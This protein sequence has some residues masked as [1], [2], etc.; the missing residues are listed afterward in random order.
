MTPRPDRPAAVPA[1]ALAA[2]IAL[3]AAPAPAAEG[4]WKGTISCTSGWGGT[5]RLAAEMTA[6]GDQMQVK[7]G[8][9]STRRPLDRNGS[10]TVGITSGQD[11]RV[12]HVR[13]TI[14]PQGLVMRQDGGEV[15]CSGLLEATAPAAPS[16]T[17]PA[18]A[19]AAAPAPSR[20]APSPA[21]VALAAPTLPLTSSRIDDIVAILQRER[22]LAAQRVDETRKLAESPD[23]AGGSAEERADF[24]SR[25]AFAKWS[26]ERNE[27]AQA[28]FR[29]AFDI[30]RQGNALP[31]L[32]RTWYQYHLGIALF[33]TGDVAQ[34]LG[35]LRQSAGDLQVPIRQRGDNE[36]RLLWH[37]VV[38]EGFLARTQ[39]ATGDLAAAEQALARAEAGFKRLAEEPGRA[40]PHE[41]AI[42]QAA[43]AQAR[44]VRAEL[45]GNAAEADEHHRAAIEALATYVSWPQ[46]RWL[47]ANRVE[48]LRYEALLAR[49]DSL[50]RAGRPAEA[51][52]I[53]RQVIDELGKGGGGQI[54][55]IV[56]A[57]RVIIEALLAQGRPADA[58]TLGWLA[59]NALSSAGGARDSALRIELQLALARAD[60]AE[61]VWPD[62]LTVFENLRTDLKGDTQRLN[63][64]LRGDPT[65]AVA[66]LKAG[67]NAE[68]LAAATAARGIAATL[69]G[70]RHPATA[71]AIG[72]R[73]AALSALGRR[74]EAMADFRLAMP[75]L[76]DAATGPYAGES[77]ARSQRLRFTVEAYL[78]ELARGIAAGP[79]GV[80][81]TGAQTLA[82]VD[83]MFRAAEA[84]RSRTLLDAIATAAVRSGLKDRALADLIRRDQ[85]AA[86]RVVALYDSLAG[87]YAL[88]GNMRRN[89]DE[90]AVRRLI[91]EAEAER[92]R[93]NR[94]IAQ[95]APSAAGLVRPLPVALNDLRLALRPG[96]ALV[97]V[98]A[99]DQR[100][101]VIAVPQQ[102]APAVLEAPVGR[103]ALAESVAK[104]RAAMNDT[105]R[106]IEALAPFDVQVAYGEIYRPLLQ[107]LEP[108]FAGA[109]RLLVVADGALAQ[110]PW[111]LLPTSA[112][113]AASGEAGVRFGEYRRVAWLIRRQS[114]AHLPSATAL[115]ALR[116]MAPTAAAPRPFIG[117]GD[118]I[119]SEGPAAPGGARRGSM[120]LRSVERSVA[121]RALEGL[122]PLPDT[123]IEL[124]QIAKVLG[125][126]PQTELYLGARASEGQ[127][128]GAAL[129]RY[130]VVAF[131]THGLA[132]GEI[133][134]LTQPALALSSPKVT[135]EQG[136]GFLTMAEVLD[137]KL[138][139]DWVVLSACNTAGAVQPGDEVLS[140]LASAFFYAGARSVLVT[141]WGVE[142]VSA[143]LLTTGAFSV[144]SPDRAEALRQSILALIDGKSGDGTAGKTK[145]AYAHPLFWAPFAL[146]GDPG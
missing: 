127:V 105:G 89:E 146:V 88:P 106:G 11:D 67:R 140:G 86:R 85:D 115:V 37:A 107:P 49:A 112:A 142:T 26:L 68:A 16:A 70:E 33:R 5:E 84:A 117:V 130:R 65:Y 13:G 100:S 131:A 39:I 126:N 25:R 133:D 40:Q 125:A 87:W 122:P 59:V 34:A 116:R 94:E 51:Q 109:K 53:A 7:L 74:D 101:Y 2:L 81:A 27:E 78:G 138:A 118:P 32:D 108:S 12:G 102:G 17:P 110:I 48:Q 134:G 113:S 79:G 45:R 92:D 20:L 10:F 56:S 90:A 23:P 124:E 58:A 31:V 22:D 132:A 91:A 64:A 4:S 129:D 38:W 18:A 141:H 21:M 55:E 52:A 135:A 57:T 96:E 41:V 143:R 97:S 128:R 54:S 75:I 1:L 119:F 24:L 95:R 63:T 15:S 145:F 9:L 69:F 28:D 71:E 83:Q 121:I 36:F 99:G 103:N 137:L 30:A 35:H 98:F 14:T 3:A 19:T 144:K 136:D 76:I 47:P 6:S 123:R 80:Q 77:G 46:N 29:R 93:L 104:L 66:L 139:A 8:T 50:A 43:L 72:A 42:S 111:A 60:A 44:A 120:R 73:A 62:A 61:G 114:V 82:V